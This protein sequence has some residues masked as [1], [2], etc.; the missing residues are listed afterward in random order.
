MNLPALPAPLPEDRPI[1]LLV[2]HAERP[3]IP[4]GSMGTDLCITEEGALAARQLGSRLGARIRSVRTSAVHRCVQTSRVIL[5]GAQVSL[6]PIE[7]PL[8]GV[9]SAFLTATP[10]AEETVR[11]LGFDRFF[12][13]LLTGEQMLPG[14]PHP[15]E[16][17]RVLREHAVEVADSPGLHLLVTHDAMIATLVARSWRAPFGL[18]SFP[19]FLESAAIWKDGARVLVAYRGECR[20]VA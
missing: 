16:G 1:A 6:E 4:E 10:E 2:R 17:A 15:A 5:A 19:G 7:D 3:P 8:L 9:P 12:E 13:H 14:M 20:P 18:D 11:R